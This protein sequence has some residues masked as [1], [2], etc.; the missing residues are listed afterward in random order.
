MS[1]TITNIDNPPPFFLGIA[2]G[3]PRTGALRVTNNSQVARGCPDCV[4]G[5]GVQRMFKSINYR[6]TLNQNALMDTYL[7]QEE[8]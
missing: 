1:R 2:I 4:E 8:L 3:S 6:I 7:T 5:E